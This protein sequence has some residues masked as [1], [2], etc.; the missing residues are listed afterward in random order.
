MRKVGILGGS[1]NP[2]HIGHLL[3]AESS[4]EEMELDKVLIMP[5]KNPPHKRKDSLLS[6]EHRINIIKLAIKSNPKIELSTMEMNRDGT[7]YT[8]DTLEILTEKEPSNQYHFILGSD[9]FYQIHNKW[10]KPELIFRLSNILVINR[11]HAA[12]D[13]IEDH[14]EF[15]KGIYKDI[16]ISIVNMPLI[17]ISSTNIRNK[18]KNGASTRYILPDNVREYIDEFNLYRD[19]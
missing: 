9:S 19:L 14:I 13:Q 10:M 1:F 6:D 7:T 12:K 3:M 16:S 5:L 8:A 18:I 15:L 11:G 17:E 4:I 2:I